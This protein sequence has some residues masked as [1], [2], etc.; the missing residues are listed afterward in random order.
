[1][2]F[3][4]WFDLK[5]SR[6]FI[7]HIHIHT[8]THTERNTEKIKGSYTEITVTYSD[9]RIVLASGARRANPGHNPKCYV[10]SIKEQ[11]LASV[12][13]CVW[14]SKA[15]NWLFILPTATRHCL[16]SILLATWQN[17]SQL[18]SILEAHTLPQTKVCVYPVYMDVC[19]CVVDI[20]LNLECLLHSTT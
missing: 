20:Y 1:M 7:T 13:E 16:Y 3:I 15:L 11:A 18:F 2:L 10:S 4:N 12:C 17:I 5:H 9:S 8:Q 19:V 14:V 6:I